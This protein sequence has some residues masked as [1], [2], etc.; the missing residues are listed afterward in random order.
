MSQQQ[1]TAGIIKI[2]ILAVG[3]Q[4]G[5]VLSNWLI[6]LA[7]N[8][9]YCAQS[10]SVPGVAQRTGATVYYVEIAPKSDPQPIFALMPTP[11][12]VDIIIAAEVMEAGRAISRGLVTN[13]KTTVITSNHRVYSVA[14]KSVPGDGRMSRQP[15]LTALKVAAKNL[16][17]FDMDTTALATNSHISTA[18]FGALAGSMALPFSR[19]SYENTITASGRGVEA[20]LACF[21]AAYAEA[22]GQERL[23][24]KNDTRQNV[25]IP[26]S[27]QQPWQELQQ[28][29][30]SM[31][32]ALQATLTLACQR[33]AA[34]Q[35]VAYAKEYLEQIQDLVSKDSDPYFTFTQAVA[36]NLVLAMCYADVIHVADAKTQ[37]NRHQKMR[38]ERN[39]GAKDVIQ[40]TDYLH[41]RSEEICGLLPHRIGRW[42]DNNSAV[43]SWLTRRYSKGIKLH[44][45]SL[46]G[47]IIL[48]GLAG[49]RRFRR[50]LW[51][52]QE[53]QLEWQQWLKLALELLPTNYQLA[54]EI[55]HCQA[56]IK[57]YG[58]TYVRGLD[59]YTA[60]IELLPQ[61]Q[62]RYDAA[63]CARV[64]R[65]C[66]LDDAKA[67]Q[68][69]KQF[70]QLKQHL[71]AN[72][73]QGIPSVNL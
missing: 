51:R 45:H 28:H 3:G 10:T 54:T 64:L 9:G 17:H 16:I 31:P 13:D 36:D 56:L 2:A 25:R 72:E 8:N 55:V 70:T 61:L 63:D 23:E 11:A 5:G 1:N 69:G 15:V 35:D 65:E 62:A 24:L 53:A 43:K 42:A 44:S 4:G 29:I 58:D 21:A 40:V 32:E 59:N 66:L 38:Q 60:I 33:L 49:M 68:Q 34:Y 22:L 67:L 14:E 47:F 39:L 6:Q 46:G 12:D 37:A 20:G 41:P 18:M 19:Q 52:H 48:Y 73:L 30:Q 27:L 57:G 50:S 71:F 26:H 7:E